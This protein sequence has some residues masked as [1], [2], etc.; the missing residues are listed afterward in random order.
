MSETDL[1]LL[2][3][4]YKKARANYNNG[5]PTGMTDAQF[6]SLEDR[7]RE[8]DPNWSELAK[9]GAKVKS[10]KTKAKLLHPMPSCNKVYPHQAD[11]WL[12]GQDQILLMDKL[13]GNA[14]QFKVHKGNTVRLI[15]R[16]DGDIG[17]DISFLIP[18]MTLP[19]GLDQKWN[20]VARCEAVM[21]ED[22]FQEHYAAKYDNARNL[23]AGILNRT[24]DG[25]PT[26]EEKL[27]LKRTDIVVLGIFGLNL[28]GS[29]TD[30]KDLGLKVVPHRHLEKPTADLLTKALAWRRKKS[31][32]AIDGLVMA[33]RGFKMDYA[34]SD[35]PKDLMAFKVNAEV[36][37]AEVI[38]VIWQVSAHGRINP[39]I[40]LKPT[41][42][43]GVT[44]EH[45]TVHNAEW[46]MDRRLGIGAIVELVRS[47]DV[48][49]KVVGVV[50]SATKLKMPSIPYK[51]KGKYLFAVKTTAS[52]ETG[53]QMKVLQITKFM[54]R[55]K[56]EGLK[57]ATVAKLIRN[58]P[59]AMFYLEQ[60]HKGTLAQRLRRCGLGPKVAEKIEQQFT[61]VFKGK[62]V[63]L[64]QLMVASHVFDAGVG[65]RKLAMI[66][67]D[68]ISMETLVAFAEDGRDPRHTMKDLVAVPGFSDKSAVLV[69]EGLE[70]FVPL[71]KKYRQMI[72][73]D[74]SIP[75]KVKPKT[76]PLSGQVVSWTSYRS[77]AEEAAVEAAG[78]TVASLGSKTTILLWKE[79]A[80]F[81]DKIEKAKARGV[82]TCHFSDLKELK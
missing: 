15:T 12:Q 54:S 58:F 5:E 22:V 41:R 81:M 71:F 51:Q 9:T 53:E 13:D 3:R 42:I 82:R 33:R 27:A 34:N 55:M 17:G 73:I 77:P 74:G 52:S 65:E 60:W 40:K 18:Y 19:Q 72:S 28:F 16:G 69:I 25:E 36:H 8:I 4:K 50:R 59:S 45:A 67:D 20:F 48:I 57:E 61:K 64:R 6:D 30:A 26:K 47:G 29:L 39:K 66:E 21:R 43:G 38:D 1:A 24:M 10:K 80:K 2:K 49:P 46:M 23:V 63:S 75:K 56:I 76:G 35:R 62:P 14:L 32:Y 68:G 11:K 37:Q 31:V 7:I 78:G 44:V 79:G 70:K